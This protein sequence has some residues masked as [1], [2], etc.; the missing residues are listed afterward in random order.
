MTRPPTK[1]AAAG[2]SCDCHMPPLTIS[3]GQLTYRNAMMGLAKYPAED[4]DRREGGALLCMGA[5]AAIQTVLTVG[6]LYASST[7]E[8]PPA[9]APTVAA[10]TFEPSIEPLAHSHPF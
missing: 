9:A 5:M 6:I 4:S 3:T 10:P 8:S 2:R 1:G 7:R